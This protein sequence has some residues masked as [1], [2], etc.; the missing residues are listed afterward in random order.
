MFH[1]QSL[2]KCLVHPNHVFIL[3]PYHYPLCTLNCI[4]EIFIKWQKMKW[5]YFV[6]FWTSISFTTIFIV[7]T[8]TTTSGYVPT[9]GSTILTC[10][11]VFIVFTS[12]STNSICG[13][14]SKGYILDTTSFIAGIVS[15]CSCYWILCGFFI[16]LTP[17]L[18]SYGFFVYISSFWTTPLLRPNSSIYTSSS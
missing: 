8:Y 2:S 15:T 12:S 11:F 9:Y 3:P 16:S 7:T 1:D 13:S 10:I 17:L 14:I 18:R 6:S 4:L 5:D